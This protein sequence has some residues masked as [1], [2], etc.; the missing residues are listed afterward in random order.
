MKE[1]GFVRKNPGRFTRDFPLA[2]RNSRGGKFG[3]L[4]I[5]GRGARARDAPTK[6]VERVHASTF[7]PTRPR[8]HGTLH[9]PPTE[10]ATGHQE[11][12]GGPT[13]NDYPSLVNYPADPLWI[14]SVDAFEVAA[15]D[16]AAPR[17]FPSVVS[18]GDPPPPPPSHGSPCPF[19]EPIV[20]GNW[21][22]FVLTLSRRT[23]V[24]GNRGG[25][26]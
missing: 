14:H 6:G 10:G 7:S 19:D 24:R 20:C 21:V 1:H 15:M 9:I 22:T 26:A 4:E 23:V 3:V 12:E 11:R 18:W 25:R 13:K 5:P 8:L 17:R 16:A 2:M